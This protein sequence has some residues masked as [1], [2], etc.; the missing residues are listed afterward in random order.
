[1]WIKHN[2]A[3]Y[4]SNYILKITN[5]G[6]KL[7]ATFKDGTE[8]IIGQFKRMKECE[9]ILSSL[10]RALVFED[11]DHPGVFIRDTK[12]SKEKANGNDKPDA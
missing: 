6:T 7:I 3:L 5:K 1:M 12:S 10:T 8:E 11:D 2:N 9:D 4:N